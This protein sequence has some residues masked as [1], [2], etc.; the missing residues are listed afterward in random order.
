MRSLSSCLSNSGWIVGNFW[1]LT[2]DFKNQC[3]IWKSKFTNV[4]KA[5][6]NEKGNEI[7]FGSQKIEIKDLNDFDQM[8][9]TLEFNHLIEFKKMKSELIIL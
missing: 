9:K 1:T 8:A 4:F 6:A 7:L 3:D 5:R 2:G